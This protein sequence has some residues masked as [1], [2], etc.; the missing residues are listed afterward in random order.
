MAI[1]EMRKLLYKF[2]FLLT[3]IGL[4]S[5]ES[6][7]SAPTKPN[8]TLPVE[9]L[10]IHSSSSSHTFNV[11]IAKTPKEQEIGEMFRPQIA[12]QSGMLFPWHFPHQSEMWM[13]NTEV[14]LD[15]VF[16]GQDRKIESIVEN[17]VPYSLATISSHGPVIAT[18]EL[19]GG[20]TQRDKIYV[21]DSVSSPTL[22]PPSS[23]QKK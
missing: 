17:A 10:V 3:A 13:K 22:T 19:P 23:P 7:H 16:I 2:F 21:G 11:E 5:V 9:K 8:P 20:E 15:I 18:L 4:F 1:L 12:P 14:P 6:A